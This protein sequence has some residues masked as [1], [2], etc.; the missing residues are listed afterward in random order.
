MT[1]NQSNRRH[2]FP[3]QNKAHC[4]LDDDTITILGPLD[5]AT[6]IFP[7]TEENLAIHTQNVS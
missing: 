2:S 1:S 5:T 3:I 6:T 4:S 7:L